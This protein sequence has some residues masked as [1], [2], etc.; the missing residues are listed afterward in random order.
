MKGEEINGAKIA[1]LL[2]RR[3]WVIDCLD[4]Y[5]P[6]QAGQPQGRHPSTAPRTVKRQYPIRVFYTAGHWL[7]INS[8]EDVVQAGNF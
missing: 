6:G 5:A 8:I 1:L 7:D 4:C 2:V 3:S